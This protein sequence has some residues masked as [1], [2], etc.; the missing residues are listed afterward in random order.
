MGTSPTGCVPEVPFLKRGST[1]YRRVS[2]SLF[3]AGVAT[4]AILW[5][6]QPIL[7]IFTHQFHV[8]PATSSLSLSL[9]TIFLAVSLP[10]AA[11]ISDIFGRKQVMT[12]SVFLASIC[13]MLTTFCPNFFTILMLRS[14][15]GI[16]LAGLPAVAMA[17]LSEEVE[18][19]SLGF[20]M[21]LYISGNTIGGLGGR[22]IVSYISDIE[23]WRTAIAALATICLLMSIF[24]WHNLPYS[25]NFLPKSQSL[26]TL[27]RSFGQQLRDPALLCLYSI[28]GL[29][30]SGFVTLYNYIGFRLLHYP[31][32]LSESFVGSI[33]VVY[34][35]GTF[36]SSWA[37][38]LADRV[39]QR[40][41]LWLNILI[42][43]AG[44]SVT[45]FSNL[46]VII[47]G[48]IIFTFGFFGGHST[49]SSWVGR[50]ALHNKSQAS[51][52]YL[53][54]YYVGSSIGGSLGGVFWSTDGW[55]GT[56]FMILVAVGASFIVSIV[57]SR[58]THVQ[59]TD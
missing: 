57:L 1:E 37:G 20:A 25:R 45:L 12:F 32:D 30:M 27:A 39:G 8:S 40:K 5:S 48:I 43:A 15:L 7:P 17:Y 2:L 53:L 22:L 44:V 6:V 24:F 23:S 38:R 35:A 51:A 16:V 52:L 49:A 41:V 19:T 42:M 36:S 14:V 10:V 34:L 3:V 31:Y 4:F 46:F 55:T 50:R 54:F 29:L 9:T 33:F 56:V 28:G 58:I 18:P 59:M 13:C 47:V 21:G 11:A 26:G